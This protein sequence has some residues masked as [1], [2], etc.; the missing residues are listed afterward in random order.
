MKI[1]R[2]LMVVALLMFAATMTSWL[3]IAGPVFSDATTI[4]LYQWAKDW[5]TLLGAILAI[6]A[7]WLAA[8]P[9]WRQLSEM[10]VQTA[11]QAYELLQRQ[12]IIVAREFEFAWAAVSAAQKG[13]MWHIAFRSQTLYPQNLSVAISTLED[14][15]Q[16]V[17]DANEKLD[18]PTSARW[19]ADIESE[20]HEVQL[21]L[22]RLN[23]ALT[24][25]VG[26]LKI[27]EITHGPTN[28]PSDP[29]WVKEY[30]EF[31]KLTVQPEIDGAVAAAEKF[32]GR[33]RWKRDELR[34]LLEEAW[35]RLIS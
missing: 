1:P 35:I 25:I 9:V 31:Q 8:R 3:G 19:P 17:R 32:A 26:R 10:Q 4:G 2:D 7:A 11:A 28:N 18:E 24:K 29:A 22:H 21:A 5:Q 6:L 12:D 33:A 20:R 14:A 13:M 27:A 30:A 16:S 15:R 34:P 23:V